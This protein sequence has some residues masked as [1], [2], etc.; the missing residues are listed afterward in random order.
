[1]EGGAL[2]VGASSE[3]ALLAVAV[4]E[5]TLLY[6]VQELEPEVFRDLRLEKL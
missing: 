6:L 4:H 2:Q 1:L 3:R 5:K